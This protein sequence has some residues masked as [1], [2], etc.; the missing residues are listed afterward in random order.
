MV[1]QLDDLR[2][3]AFGELR[4]AGRVVEVSWHAGVPAQPVKRG[5]VCK[6]SPASR[7]RL[8]KVSG[9]VDWDGL[10]AEWGGD[11]LFVTL[12]YRDDPGPERSKRDLD[13]LARRW[14]R[15]WGSCRWLWKMEFQRRGV[16]HFHVLAWV[17]KAGV[18]AL[19]GYRLWLWRA[20]REIAGN[21]LQLRVDADY[22]RANDMVRYFVAYS[23]LGRKEYQHIVPHNWR[24]SSGRWWGKRG[25]PVSWSTH[26]L[27]RGEYAAVRR[28]LVRYR[29]SR[30]P[31][32]IRGPRSMSG[33]WV[34]GQRT[35]S[36][37]HGVQRVLTES[38]RGSPLP[39]P[40]HS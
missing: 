37:Q 27:S 2:P 17:P 7:R 23:S 24:M 28:L 1:A 12:T 4:A 11:W 15:R 39:Y 26:R 35:G 25:L 10:R 33:C 30:S 18:S 34:L 5:R 36:L 8:L 9:S 16:V 22:S 21:G 14:A 13:V 20:W 3:D 38:V 19:V 40:G 29:R 32:R 31:G 6:W